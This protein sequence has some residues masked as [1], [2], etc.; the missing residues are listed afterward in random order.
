M[1]S[2][3][4]NMAGKLVYQNVK[5]I[6]TIIG[7]KWEWNGMGWK[8]DDKSNSHLKITK[9][10]CSRKSFACRVYTI[11]ISH[12]VGFHRFHMLG[13]FVTSSNLMRLVWNRIESEPKVSCTL[14][15]NIFF[16]RSNAKSSHSK[17]VVWSNIWMEKRSLLLISKVRLRVICKYILRCGC[18]SA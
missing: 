3:G 2:L 15:A 12:T 11:T 6:C 5:R 4:G 8:I 10:L 14:T 17:F 18:R 1:N 13:S 7:N 9:R 16:C